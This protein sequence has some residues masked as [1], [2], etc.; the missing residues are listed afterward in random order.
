MKENRRDSSHRG[1][2]RD[3]N[4]REFL[5]ATAPIERLVWLHFAIPR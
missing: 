5:R 1:Y 4:R 3:S 2:A